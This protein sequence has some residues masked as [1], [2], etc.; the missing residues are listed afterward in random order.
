MGSTATPYPHAQ[1]SH[2]VP[3]LQGKHTPVGQLHELWVSS[4][5]SRRCHSLGSEAARGRGDDMQRPQVRPSGLPPAP[6]RHQERLEEG[7]CRRW[8]SSAGAQGSIPGHAEVVIPYAF[9]LARHLRETLHP[10]RQADVTRQPARQDP[11]LGLGDL[12]DE[13]W[14][15][16]HLWKLWEAARCS[17]V[18][19][20]TG[21]G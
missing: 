6:A 13:S 8:Y 19:I 9:V 4:V 1:Q 18:Q 14:G 10:R 3:M 20:C 2:H 21:H 5:P 15:L 17:E 12:I 16:T 11:P 7:R